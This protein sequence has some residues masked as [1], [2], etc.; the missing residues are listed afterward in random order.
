MPLQYNLRFLKFG[1][2]IICTAIL[3]L[4]TMFRTLFMT[5]TYRMNGA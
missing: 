4:L 3:I 2:L 1:K 5:M